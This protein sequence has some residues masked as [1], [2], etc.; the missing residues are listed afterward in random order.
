MKSFFLISIPLVIFYT[1][2]IL[3]YQI[4]QEKF[5]EVNF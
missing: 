1:L 2:P 5:Y 4:L 3:P